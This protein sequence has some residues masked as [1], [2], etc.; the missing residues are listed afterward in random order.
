MKFRHAIS[1]LFLLIFLSKMLISVAPV[2]VDQIDS[3]TINLVIMQLEIQHPD[4]HDYKDLSHKQA[5]ATYDNNSLFNLT[6]IALLVSK[7]YIK[8]NKKHIRTYF[9]L[10]PT[11]PPNYAC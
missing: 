4:L 1:K 7:R 3:K 9:P 5:F 2:I 8:N 10:I 6:P 11:P